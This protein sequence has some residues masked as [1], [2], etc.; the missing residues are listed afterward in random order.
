MKL[1]SLAE[2]SHATFVDLLHS[3]FQVQADAAA[4]V[5]IELVEA[6]AHSGRAPAR[7]LAESFS[8][9][10]AG[11]RQPFLPQR[12]YRLAHERLGTFDLFIVPIG[13]DQTG[14]RYE[15]VFNRSARPGAAEGTL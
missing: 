14:F 10:F 11:P 3:R 4:P 2:F 6:V 1:V 8:L 13:E 5:E 9:V 15:A 12:T 7:S